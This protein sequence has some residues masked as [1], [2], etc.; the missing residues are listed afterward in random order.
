MQ[1]DVWVVRNTTSNLLVGV[2]TT[3]DL[4]IKASSQAMVATK[5]ECSIDMQLI[6]LDKIQINAEDVANWLNS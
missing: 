3:R 4:A 5:E 1:N 2:F 6:E